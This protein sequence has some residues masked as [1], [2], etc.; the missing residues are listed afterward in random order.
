MSNKV[1]S[2]W[3]WVPSLYFAEGLPYIFVMSV[4]VVF[5]KAMGLSN[6]LI[7]YYTGW[8]Y[9]PW[10]IKPFWSPFVEMFKTKRWWIISM[11]VILGGSLAGI[12]FSIPLPNYLQYTLAFFW[13]I[14]FSS[15]TYDIV[16]DGFY[17]LA[18][19]EHNQ[20]FF[21]GFRNTFYRLAMVV[22]QGP[23]VILAGSLSEKTGNTPFAWSITAGCISIIFFSLS[24]YHRFILPKPSDTTQ[25][26]KQSISTFFHTFT[27]YFK[28]E[29]IT[30][31]VIFILLFRLG[32]AQLTKIATP[33]LLDNV[34]AGGL[35]LTV[36]KQGLA[37]GTVGVLALLTGGILGGLLVAKHGIG[38]WLWPMALAMNIP[39][40]LYIYL[41]YAKPESMWIISAV[42][43]VEQFG[44][45]FGNTAFM[46]FLLY[47]S[48]GK[49][50]TAHYA[51]S[52]GIMALG[53]MI[54]GMASG[55][56]QT[57]VGYT[58][59]FI[60]VCLSTIPGLVLLKWLT[61][62]KAFGKKQIK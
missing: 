2:P 31:S 44:F 61:L 50:E 21:L 28:K 62:D 29:H 26:N 48:K 6:E 49:H 51:I 47:F 45:G 58:N 59:F 25:S 33:F 19:D 56:I 36:E 16:A 17:M 7:T 22:L 41:S 43:G 38:K 20:S 27:T 32:E 60:F 13:L 14:A 54:P 4:A 35:G 46:I 1:K 11:Q 42:V 55:W 40:L 18:L 53:M 37:Y 34:S 10:V 52:T 8:F 15:A 39:N 12:A 57:H 23:M 24:I 9:L 5:Y 30:Y 3:S